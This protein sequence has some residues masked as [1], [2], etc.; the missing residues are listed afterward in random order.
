MNALLN[1]LRGSAS[2]QARSDDAGFSIVEVM[3]ALM[4]FAVLAVCIAGSLT[5]GLVLTNASRGRE[6][7]INLASQDVDNMRITAL[8]TPAGVF[9]V[10]STPSPI[11]YTVGGAKFSLS[12]TVD[13]VT[14]TGGSGAC[15]TGSGTLA[16]KSVVDKV[17]WKENSNT[18]STTMTTLV[19]PISN[20]NSDTAGTIIVA[21]IGASGAAESGVSISI[22]P[23]SGGGGATLAQQPSKTDSDGCSF[24][25]N[26]Q[27]GTYTVTAT[28]TGGI[29]FQQHA[30]ASN[31]NVV[32]TAG[33]N[34]M[35]NFTYDQADT[36]KF[37]YPSGATL[38]TNMP[39]TFINDVAGASQ[40]AASPTTVSAFPYPDGYQV[41]AGTY[42]YAA[43][44][45]S[46]TCIDTNPQTW[47]TDAT[48]GAVPPD[49]SA[50]T[51]GVTAPGAASNP[52]TLAVGMGVVKVSGITTSTF[53]TAVST[54]GPAGTPDPGC[55]S[56]QT[57]TFPKSTGTSQTIALPFGTWSIFTGTTS[58]AKTTNYI[59]TKP[60]NVTVST[61]GTIDST[62]T[63]TVMVDPRVAS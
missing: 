6:V 39:L 18:F 11:V 40:F 30:P 36:F 9:S 42:V 38:P 58:G 54:P 17:S 48:S 5:S 10:T 47:P 27:P 61:T 45:G 19:A 15:G 22:T 31:A 24:G 51:M 16:Y 55:L 13:W 46:S 20:I 52:A 56:V 3:V 37:T 2:R 4:V 25:L 43:G 57:L 34:T 33:Q 35:V 60:T 23:N 41:V 12:R 44:G 1:R 8:G 14:T 32:V 50:S 29:D 59:K 26:A 21:I 49:V 28:E 62:T 7:A 63:F 53:V